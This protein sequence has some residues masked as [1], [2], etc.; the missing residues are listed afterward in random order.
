MG[1][2]WL[3]D[4]R[5]PSGFSVGIV[6]GSP[7]PRGGEKGVGSPAT[8]PELNPSAALL[9]QV[10]LSVLEA[11][12]ANTE[13]LSPPDLGEKPNFLDHEVGGVA[14][15]MAGSRSSVVLPGLCPCI[16]TP[17]VRMASCVALSFLVWLRVGS[18]WL[19]G[20]T[21]HPVVGTTTL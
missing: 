16:L 10:P 14:S 20:H 11:S 13:N 1:W 18:D 8:G 7:G 4:Q 21:A 6:T 9:T 12:G 17:L 2:G 3:L 5:C 19:C 15:G